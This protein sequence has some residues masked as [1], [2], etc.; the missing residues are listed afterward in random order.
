MLSLN[1]SYQNSKVSLTI[2]CRYKYFD[3]TAQRTE[4]RG[5]KFYFCRLPFA[6]TVKLNLT[7]KWATP[8]FAELEKFTLN[9]FKLVVCNLFLIFSILNHP[10]SYYILLLS[11]VFFH[12]IK[13]LFSGFIIFFFSRREF[14][15]AALD[16]RRNTRSRLFLE[17]FSSV[18]CKPV[19][20]HL[21]FLNIS[22][23]TGL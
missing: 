3:S 4:D 13:L 23:D 6:V 19:L 2:H 1:K 20:R 18:D 12:F 21:N 9:I 16:R 17:Y 5:Q 15:H 22:V 8:C 14:G 7:I 11:M 10:C